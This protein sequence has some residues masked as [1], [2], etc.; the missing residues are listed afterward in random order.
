MSYLEIS[1]LPLRTFASLEDLQEQADRWAEE[2]A[3][4]RHHF[5]IR[6][7]VRD[8]YLA[9]HHFLVALPDPLPDTDQQSEKRR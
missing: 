6:A 9:G 4:P 2:V 5:R 7:R 3:W 8:A 1:F